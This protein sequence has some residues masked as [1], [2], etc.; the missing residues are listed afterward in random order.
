MIAM[1]SFASVS[2]AQV[3][4]TV[5]NSSISASI[6]VSGQLN[7][8]NVAGRF[9]VTRI[10]PA[11]TMMSM[12]GSATKQSYVTI[13][14]DGGTQPLPTGATVQPAGWDL[15]FGDTGTTTFA[16]TGAWLKPPTVVP[17]QNRI[18]AQWHTL[19][20][21]ITKLTTPVIEVDL[22][23]SLVHDMVIY[24]FTIKNE[25]TT[26]HTIGLRF[27]EDFEGPNGVPD[28][29]VLTSSTAPITIETNLGAGQVPQYYRRVDP[30][31][32]NSV[33][34]ILKP[35]TGSQIIPTPPDRIGFG[36]PDD[37]A[38]GQGVVST[39]QGTPYTPL[40]DYIP[41]PTNDFSVA[42]GDAAAAVY[43]NPTY[44]LPNQSNVITTTFGAEAGTY[45]FDP[46]LAVGL[47]APDALKYT[48][49]PTKTT[50]AAQLAPNP[51]SVTSFVQ[52]MVNS[53]ISNITASIDLPSGL[54]LVSGQTATQSISSLPAYTE[55]SIS[56][57]VQPTG[58]A[59]GPQVVHVTLNE[60]TFG[61]GKALSKEIDVPALPV[62]TFPGTL[63][64]VSFPYRFADPTPTN[65]TG[66]NPSVKFLMWNQD[67]G[68]YQSA[69]ALQPG[70]G[71]FVNLPLQQTVTLN[72]SS[73]LPDNTLS[74]SIP[75]KVG[76]N[77]IGN[78]FLY[79]M[80]WSDVT[81]QSYNANDPNP[82]FSPIS[83][84]TASDLQH[85]W[86]GSAIYR[87]D[88]T[89]QQ[90]MFDQ[91]FS[92]IIQPFVG[93]WVLS[94]RANVT[95]VFPK[96]VDASLVPPITSTTT[97]SAASRAMKGGWKV[98]LVAESN[99]T[100][101]TCNY[102]GVSPN[103]TDAYNP[104]DVE[105]PPSPGRSVSLGI[106]HSDWGSNNGTFA[107]DI[108]GSVTGRKV[109]NLRLTSPQPNAD[110]KL[111]WPGIQSVPRSMILMLTDNAT[112]RSWMM[113][114][115]SS[116]SI[117]TGASGQSS[118]SV[119]LQP[120][121]A[122]GAFRFVSWDIAATRANNGSVISVSATQDAMISVKIMNASGQLVRDLG[123]RPSSSRSASLSW[124]YRDSRGASLPAGAYLVEIRGATQD[125]Q[126]AKVIVPHMIVR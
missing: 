124:D 48:P 20:T 39:V 4:A 49:D 117:N 33:G 15:I 81:V 95:L 69:S 80:K 35:L 91:D 46:P 34:A 85:N 70:Q 123:S 41:D 13:R 101:D 83:V 125:G 82:S 54:Q 108:R 79:P 94:K 40:W 30:S 118:L 26:P 43:F 86:M 19:P 63:Q 1:M 38:N 64:M 66:M 113:N 89:S 111:T 65:A 60:G 50:L 37:F 126:T 44:Y 36:G 93:Y 21:V 6:G 14:I 29:P 59:A 119:I 47:N 53:P 90:Y 28:G 84:Q 115:T 51:F 58:A 2:G 24:K 62:Q 107:Q 77:Q 102:I 3:Y 121:T 109:W 67:M 114:Q 9:G 52:N 45:N 100:S 110:V 18:V 98:Q 55:G 112:G 72:G 99:N 5:A 68:I 56:W 32:Q 11:G 42:G 57:K 71:Y 17:G 73:P 104:A 27:C 74:Y 7:S 92:T 16:G 88:V 75:L 8:T 22:D 105:K 23:M 76:W 116:V 122:A 120:R 61:T 97:L 78:P 96:P 10:N 106:L 103:A 31:T 12:V 25:D 87:F